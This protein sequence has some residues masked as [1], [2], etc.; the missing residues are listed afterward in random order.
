MASYATR[1]FVVAVLMLATDYSAL[2]RNARAENGCYIKRWSAFVQGVLR[3]FEKEVCSG[4]SSSGGVDAQPSIFDDANASVDEVVDGVCE[5][6]IDLLEVT[7]DYC[8][9]SATDASIPAL[10]RQA[11]EDTE[12]PQSQLQVQPPN[13]RTMVNF[14]T[15][16]FTERE[17]MTRSVNLLGQP[18]DLRIYPVQFTWHFEPGASA[19]TT[20]PGAPYPDHSITHRYLRTGTYSPSVDTTYG[21]D[22]RVGGGAW[23]QVPGTVTIEGAPIEL[24][25]VEV[26]PTLV[27]TAYGR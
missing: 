2:P 25:A 8:D 12:L 11:F 9:E 22:W 7:P 5:A 20:G 19:T 13:G 6:V 24:E 1:V 18:V 4:S 23:Q 17:P 3:T 15:I 26:R 27:E 10:V 14:D 21:A 16:Y